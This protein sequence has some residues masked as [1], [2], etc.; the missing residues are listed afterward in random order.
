MK[1]AASKDKI[2]WIYINRIL[3]CIATFIISIV[4]IMYLHNIVIQN[5]YTE[6]TADYDVIGQMAEKDQKNAMAVT[7]SDNDYI[8]HFKGNSTVTQ[9]EIARVMERGTVN[10]DY[11]ESSDA[12]IAEA[13]ER[14][15]GKLQIVNSEN[16]QWF[17]VLLA[18]VFAVIAYNAP[19]WMLK[20]QAKMRQLEMEDEVMQFQTIILMLMRIERVN[21]EIILEWLERYA[22]IFKEPISKCVNNYESG[23]W[24]ALEQLKEDVSYQQF[25]RIVESLQAA[26][27]KIPI[28]DAF[29]ELDTERDYYQARRKESNERLISR[30]GM[31]GRGI[32]FAPMI[33]I[34]VGYLIIPLVFIGMTSM[35]E[36]MSGLTTSY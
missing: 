15:L 25:I 7:E 36:S 26:V 29:D 6:P 34:F 21:V 3:L 31:I 19:V 24:E 35:S 12:E 32:G 14:V 17:E 9:D 1:E 33:V 22:N 18:M 4:I 2:E 30:K 23:P 10:H 20:F 11:E 13:A 5:V 16:M 27:E 8:L 28:A